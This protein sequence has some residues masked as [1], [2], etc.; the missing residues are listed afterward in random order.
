M[1]PRAASEGALAGGVT[2]IVVVDAYGHG[3]NL[4]REPL[5]AAAELV[6]GSIRPL[7]IRQELD[8]SFAGVLFVGYPAMAGMARGVLNHTKMGRE[9]HNVL[10]NDDPPARSA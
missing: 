4:L 1:T 3:R 2:E 9:I 7:L 6:Q 8:G 10:P 5:H